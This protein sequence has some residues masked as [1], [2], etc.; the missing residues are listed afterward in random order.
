[1]V[2]ELDKNLIKHGVVKDPIKPTDNL[3][4]IPFIRAFDLRDP[5]GQSE[6]IMDFYREFDKINKKFQSISALEKRGDFDEAIK[7]RQEIKDKNE[8]YLISV[9]D[10]IKE[11]NSVIRTIYNTKEYS[12]DEKRELIDIHYLLM[13]KS[14]KRGLDYINNK[15]EV[16]QEK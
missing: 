4:G 3:T 15:V 7:I 8:L 16:E 9:R 6:Y 14:A 1:M 2:R 10:A 11:L 12:P 5:S 13:I